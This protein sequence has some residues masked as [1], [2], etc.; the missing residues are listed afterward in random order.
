ML[1]VP[2]SS[3]AGGLAQ[4]ECLPEGDPELSRHQA[5]EHKVHCAVGQGQQIHHL[6]E[7][8]YNHCGDGGGFGI[9]GGC[10]CAVEGGGRYYDDGV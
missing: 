4:M 1:P 10:R 2:P 3:L 9:C 8:E 5:V 6:V 7:E